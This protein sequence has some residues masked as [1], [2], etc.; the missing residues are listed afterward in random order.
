MRLPVVGAR[1]HREIRERG[2]PLV[3]HDIQIARV[4]ARHRQGERERARQVGVL[5]DLELGEC[6]DEIRRARAVR[7]DV[8]GGAQAEPSFGMPISGR[9]ASASGAGALLA[10]HSRQN[11]VA[12]FR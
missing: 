6:A 9:A 2:E 7:Q 1:H 8:E 3:V 5:L 10:S 4:R 12:S 11:A